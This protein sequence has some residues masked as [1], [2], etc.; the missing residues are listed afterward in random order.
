MS[1]LGGFDGFNLVT[2]E[3]SF[4]TESLFSD[5][6]LDFGSLVEGLVSLLNF[7]VDNVSLDIIEF[8]VKVEVLDDSVS[9]LLSKSVGEFNI[10]ESSNFLISLGNNSEHDNGKVGSGDATSHG[11]SLTFTSSSGSESCSALSEK[12]SGSTVDQ[13]TLFHWETLLVISSG[14][15]EDVT[16]EVFSHEFSIDFLAHTAIIEGTNV[17]FFINFN[18]LIS[19][20]LGVTN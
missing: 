20:C 1:F 17:F 11:F 8:L 13:D 4:S 16:F 15:S 14:D 10:G 19:S 12:D 5:H 3:D 18:F 7:T 9:S 6:T 2:L